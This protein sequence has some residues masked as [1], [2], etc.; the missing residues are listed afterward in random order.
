[1]GLVRHVSQGGLQVGHELRHGGATGP[2]RGPSRRG[3]AAP[4]TVPRTALAWGA[5]LTTQRSDARDGVTQANAAKQPTADAAGPSQH[6]LENLYGR[7]R[8]RRRTSPT[9]LV[10]G[11]YDSPRRGGASP[12]GRLAEGA[13]SRMGAARGPQVAASSS[14]ARITL[15]RSAIFQPFP[16]T[17]EIATIR[18]AATLFSDDPNT[19]FQMLYSSLLRPTL[20]YSYPH[21]YDITRET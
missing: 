18:V 8:R 10:V 19:L 11:A 16:A 20:V 6:P 5:A 17:L 15:T 4:R 2:G 13:R 12:R 3:A 21:A 14:T 7:D 1:M 9:R